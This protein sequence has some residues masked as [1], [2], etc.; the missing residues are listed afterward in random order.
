MWTSH[1]P[2]VIESNCACEVLNYCTF[3]LNIQ[4]SSCLS[5]ETSKSS[6]SVDFMSTKSNRVHFVFEHACHI[7]GTNLEPK[8]VAN[9]HTQW[10]LQKGEG[11]R[12]FS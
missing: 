8:C 3:H 5:F 4:M 1:S 12:T 10:V 6:I 11:E 9:C 2:K 7:S